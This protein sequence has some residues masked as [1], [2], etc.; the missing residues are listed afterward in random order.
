M[1]SRDLSRLFQSPSELPQIRKLERGG[2]RFLVQQYSGEFGGT[3]PYEE[4]QMASQRV[5]EDILR[6]FRKKLSW[7]RVEM[8]RIERK[9]GVS[10]GMMNHNH[11]ESSGWIP[12]RLIHG[13]FA[14]DCIPCS[15]LYTAT[16]QLPTS[17]WPILSP[18]ISCG[19]LFSA[20]PG[21]GIFDL[22]G[23]LWEERS[24][25]VDRCV[26]SSRVI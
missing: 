1:G 22:P 18:A 7:F 17:L 8:Y 19:E 24:H 15:A 12:A 10:T 9:I 21:P 2:Q 14:L 5:P 25:L 6:Y 16:V 20:A 4:G 23:A 26:T 11:V 3:C 13:I